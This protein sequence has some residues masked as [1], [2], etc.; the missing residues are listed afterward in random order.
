MSASLPSPPPRPSDT[1]T[2]DAKQ[3]QRSVSTSAVRSWSL[4]QCCPVD[5]GCAEFLP[6][7]IRRHIDMPR[8][9]V[10]SVSNLSG[11]RLIGQEELYL[12]FAAS[13]SGSAALPEVSLGPNGPMPQSPFAPVNTGM[14]AQGAFCSASIQG[15]DSISR[16]NSMNSVKQS[17]LLPAQLPSASHGYLAT[18]GGV[19]AAGDVVDAV[20]GAASKTLAEAGASGRRK[21]T[22]SRL[23]KATLHR[24]DE[25]PQRSRAGNSELK[26]SDPR[27]GYIEEV[28]RCEKEERSRGGVAGGGAVSGCSSMS[29]QPKFADAEAAGSGSA[30]GGDCGGRKSAS[31][32]LTILQ[33]DRSTMVTTIDVRAQCER[34]TSRGK[35]R[36]SVSLLSILPAWPAISKTLPSVLSLN[37]CGYFHVRQCALLR[38]PCIL[39]KNALALRLSKVCLE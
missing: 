14:R 8:L 36:T 6:S 28:R 21:S 30:D 32:N 22:G 4:D 24:H 1:I 3:G 35:V 5:Q 39:R 13:A 7:S 2:S 23:T 29:S 11:P 33:D 9:P 15:M 12:E 38:V 31:R 34:C 20:P 18:G 17:S 10:D 37:R 19:G 25:R 26:A 27:G 16:V